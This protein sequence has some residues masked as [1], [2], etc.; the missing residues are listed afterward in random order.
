M[1][2]DSYR[3]DDLIS[4]PPAGTV[5]V[6]KIGSW[7]ILF[8]RAEQNI[9]IVPIDYHPEPFRISLSDL[10]ALQ[11]ALALQPFPQPVTTT[12]STSTPK[13]SSTPKQK[14]AKKKRRHSKRKKRGH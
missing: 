10:N 1:D 5:L 4:R 11:A 9:Y 14:P 12:S 2:E 3:G 7:N 13:T 8:S 6:R